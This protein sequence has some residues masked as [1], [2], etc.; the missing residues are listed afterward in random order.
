MSLHKQIAVAIKR[1][2]RSYFFE[3]YDKQARSVIRALEQQ[4]YV[5][6]PREPDEGLLKQVADSIST[7]RMRPEEHVRNVYLTLQKLI[8]RS[9]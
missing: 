1:A 7:G 3:N 8:E 4:G 9:S 2:D 5:I 6:L